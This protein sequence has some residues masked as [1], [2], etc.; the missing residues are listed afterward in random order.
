MIL[1][2]SMCWI[3]FGFLPQC[4]KCFKILKSIVNRRSLY[5][6]QYYIM[7]EKRWPFRPQSPL[8]FFHILY[9]IMTFN[10]G[11]TSVHKKSFKFFVQIPPAAEK[12]KKFYKIHTGAKIL[13]SSKNSHFENLIFHKIQKLRNK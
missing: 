6:C 7:Y 9:Q 10:L 1:G 4:G 11:K 8:H 3:K 12:E 13:N 2:F 5:S